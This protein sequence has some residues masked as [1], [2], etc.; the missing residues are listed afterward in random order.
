M[1]PR[2]QP[3]KYQKPRSRLISV[4][5]AVL[6]LSAA[7]FLGVLYM[8][9][10]AQG[11]FR[12][13][14]QRVRES[15]AAAEQTQIPTAARTEPSAT[16][17]TVMETIPETTAPEILEQYRQLYEENPDLFGWITIPGSQI[18]YPVMRT[19]DE[20]EKYLHANFQ[21]E[22]SF[23]GT[24]FLEDACTLESD[25]IIIYAHNMLDGSMFR[26][27]FRYEQSNYWRDNPIIQFNTLYEEGEYEILAAFYDR[28]YYKTEDC[29]KF[30]QFIDAENEE[31]F[32][33][34]IGQ[35][36]SKA[37]YDTGV[38]AQYGDKLITL[39]TCSY[40]VDNG[41]FVVVARKK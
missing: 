8:T 28:V 27:L 3:G 11:Q 16:P 17:E 2:K 25:N 21:G 40:H 22:Y 38:T 9:L 41:R 33:E 12:Q 36:K 24:P 4:L 37:L 32:N 34:A 1:K 19:P 13:L 31:D 35:F 7:V 10:N 14:S 26:G 6:A 5:W 20:P 30:Y 29:F 15:T 18:D 23:A 39:V